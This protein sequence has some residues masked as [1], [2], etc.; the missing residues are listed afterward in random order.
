MP[1]QPGRIVLVRHGE[2]EWSATGRHT[3]HTD[4]PLTEAGR[5]DAE[6]I[7]P[8][9]AEFRFGLVLTSPMRRASDT[10]R[11]AGLGDVAEVDDNLMEWNYGDY[12]GLT[13]P[14][15]RETVTEWRVWTHP[16]PN[17]EPVESVTARADRVIDRCGSVVERGDDAALFGHGHM[18]RVIAA[19]WIGLGAADGQRFALG[20]GSVSV[21]DHERESAVIER[22]NVRPIPVRS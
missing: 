19:R 3:S 5:R 18:S 8:A 6:A 11:L 17:G 16:T 4:V 22:W 14:E 7:G 1:S 9:L 15:I 2:T 20:A 10:C 13:T 12:E 21:L